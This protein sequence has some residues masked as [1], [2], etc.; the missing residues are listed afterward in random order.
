M[1]A[2]QAVSHDERGALREQRISGV[3]GPFSSFKSLAPAFMMCSERPRCCLRTAATSNSSSSARK[4]QPDRLS[5]TMREERCE[6]NG[7]LQ[8]F[9]DT[10]AVKRV[11]KG[12]YVQSIL[13]TG[14]HTRRTLRGGGLAT[15]AW[16]RWPQSGPPC[17]AVS[18]P[19]VPAP[20]VRPL[21][22]AP[23]RNLGARRAQPTQPPHSTTSDRPQPAQGVPGGPKMRQPPQKALFLCARGMNHA[24]ARGR[25]FAQ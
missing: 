9:C 21:R 14:A 4:C 5:V 18:A 22:H 3:L 17:S 24:I 16:P 25:S 2:G 19:C 8:F 13:R 6:S 10:A 1:S 12:R 20:P 7:S 23:Y 11:S 15:V